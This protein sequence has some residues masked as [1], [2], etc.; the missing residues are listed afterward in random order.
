MKPQHAFDPNSARRTLF[1]ATIEASATYGVKRTILSDADKQALTYKRLILGALVLGDKM[2]HI[3]NPGEKVGVFLPNAAGAAVTLLGLNAF[4][5]TAALLNFTA[6][7]RNLVSALQTGPIPIVLTSRRFV[8]AAKLEDVVAAMAAAEPTPGIRTRIV[9][10]EDLRKSISLTDKLRGALR[11]LYPKQF[12]RRFGM[13]PDS[14]AVILFTSGTEGLPKGVVLTNSNLVANAQQILAHAGG[15]LT[16]DDVVLNPLPM[17]HSFGLTAAT[18]MPLLGGMHVVLYPSPLHYK[19]VARTISETRATVLFATDTFLM[20]YA[21][22]AAKSELTSV[23]YVIAG[24]ERVKDAT[25]TAWDKAGA[26][27]LEGY[28][29]TECSPVIAC[30]LPNPNRPGTVGPLLPGLDVKLEQVPGISEGGRLKIRGPNVMAGY[31]LADTPGAL[32]K[33]DGGWHDTGDIVTIDDNSVLTIRGRAKRFA[34]IGGEMVSLAAVE[35]LASGHW[36]D[37]QHVVVTIPD[38]RK[39]EQLILVTDKA[40]A[41]KAELAEYFKTMGVTELWLPRGVL[42]VEGIPVSAAGKVDLQA[43]QRLVENTRPLL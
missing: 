35:A 3:T 10:L 16:P 36:P 24:A 43:T 15:M 28:G 26:L 5:R 21:R 31:I 25:R 23:R 1:E 41:D 20:G 33:P 14:P 7:S 22:A 39:G 19:Q 37:A 40:D 12:A 32:Q 18:L 42:V 4:G 38:A 9:Y 8:A 27:I 13:T 30:N 11:N 17:F 2:A 6:G 29:A 34:K